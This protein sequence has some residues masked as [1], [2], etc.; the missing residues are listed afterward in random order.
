MD[1]YIGKGIGLSLLIFIYYDAVIWRHII[2]R[3]DTTNSS[4]D[5]YYI[6]DTMSAVDARFEAQKI[7]FAPFSFQAAYAMM[8]LGILAALLKSGETGLTENEIAEKCSVSS[9]GISVLTQIGLGL[10]ILKLSE[11]GRLIL[12]KIGYFLADDYLT[13][14]NMDF[15]QDVCYDGAK[16]LEASIRS[17]RPEGLKV[18]GDKWKTVYEALAY[19]PERVR[20]SWFAFDHN[21]SDNIFPETLDIV[22]SDKPAKLYDI[23]GN[24]ARWA[25]TCVKHDP[26]VQVTIIDLPGQT[27]VAERNA[28]KEGFADRIKTCPMNILADDSAVPEGADV[29]WMSQFLDCF[30]PEEITKICAKVAAA[31]CDKTKIYV[32]EP[33]IDKQRFRASSFCL[34]ETSLYF[35][36]IANGNSRM[37]TYAD[38]VPAIE[39]G[40]LRLETAHHNLGI[41]SYT[42]L[43]F[44]R[45]AQ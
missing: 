37:Y 2:S 5:T 20:K 10:G 3:K 28:A 18:F 35:T 8:Q 1:R 26:D 36:C 32:L 45:N 27:V 22:F 21:Y 9:Y 38:I 6:E 25:L 16:Y 12:S 30:S 40:G 42:L 13:K 4:M 11:N 23:G 33:L 15:M 17:G 41:F 43:V 29:I 31:S 19:L 34:Q 7:A 44:R 39:R 14:V 24:T